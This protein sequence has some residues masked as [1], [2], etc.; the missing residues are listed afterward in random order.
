MERLTFMCSQQTM[1]SP[2]IRSFT[3]NHPLP[4]LFCKWYKQ[5]ICM[6]PVSRTDYLFR[7]SCYKVFITSTKC[8]LFRWKIRQRIITKQW[9]HLYS[10]CRLKCSAMN[11]H[12]V[13]LHFRSNAC[14]ENCNIMQTAITL[15]DACSW[16]TWQN[17]KVKWELFA[18]G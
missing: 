6:F 13:N 1:T 9:C 7:K 4:K 8:L 18:L 11:D 10:P 2:P 17:Y 5:S 16:R 3:S 15:H 12:T 14:F